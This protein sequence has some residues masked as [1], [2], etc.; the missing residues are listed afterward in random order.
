M[1][2]LEVFIEIKGLGKGINS[3]HMWPKHGAICHGNPR[4]LVPPNSGPSQIA[5]FRI[6]GFLILNHQLPS[7]P[8]HEV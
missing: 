5:Y 4:L 3:P 8:I 2:A 6:S 7:T 1:I